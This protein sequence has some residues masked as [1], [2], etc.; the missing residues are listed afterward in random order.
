MR[1]VTLVVVAGAVS[2]PGWPARAETTR[3]RI[4][5]SAS[6]GGAWRV[7][8]QENEQAEPL[9][10]TPA[11]GRDYVAPAIGRDKQSVAVEVS[12]QGIAICRVTSPPSCT[13]LDV[14]GAGAARPT[15]AGPAPALVFVRFT[16]GATAEDSV[17]MR[18]DEAQQ[19]VAPI[20]TH[21]GVQDHP[22]VSPDGRAV[23]YSTT[24]I[25]SIGKGKPRVRQSLWVAELS[26]HAARQ[27]TMGDWQDV[28]ADWSPDGRRI[29]FASNRRG[30]QFDVWTIAA[31]GTGE[32]VVTEGSGTKT[33]P[34]WGPDGSRILFAQ[35]IDGRQ[36][37]WMA[38]LT[39]G[40]SQ[41][42]R[43]FGTKRVELRDPDWR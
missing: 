36:E 26:E 25:V 16:T 31:D 28:H 29:A 42:Y 35:M 43:P 15:W 11:D 20:V 8:V 17:L 19:A 6:E 3:A 4:A 23:V 39:G 22:D 18:L 24:A 9:A 34:A 33:W 1:R 2:A 7:Y 38:A 14:A 27:L 37:L 10:I 40:A 5:F 12:G 13:R 41:P 30:E 21:T 32:R